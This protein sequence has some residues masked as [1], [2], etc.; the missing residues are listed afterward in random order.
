MRDMS[1]TIRPATE[2]DFAAIV[3][4][5]RE[6]ARFEHLEERMTNSVEQMNAEKEYFNCF[7]AVDNKNEIVWYAT[8]F[9]AYFTLTGKALYMDYLYVQDGHR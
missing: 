3:E 8:Y 6:F 5:F 2:D 1:I 4:L 9:F 7:V